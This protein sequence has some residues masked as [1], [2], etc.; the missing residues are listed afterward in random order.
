M[1][2][3]C[4]EHFY[5]AISYSLAECEE[6]RDGGGRD[7]PIQQKVQMKEKKT[8]HH[9]PHYFRRVCARENENDSERGETITTT[10]KRGASLPLFGQ[11]RSSYDLH[12]YFTVTKRS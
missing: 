7:A 2:T 1:R 4:G 9:T 8:H 12:S 3:W 5:S 6:K 10:T 11:H